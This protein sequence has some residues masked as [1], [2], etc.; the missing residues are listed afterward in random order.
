M[1]VDA[2]NV[3]VVAG[4]P[5]ILGGGAWLLVGPYLV[6]ALVQLAL[7]FLV[8]AVVAVAM[9]GVLFWFVGRDDGGPTDGSTG[10]RVTGE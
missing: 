9:Y 4:A 10:E 5:V 7:F 8:L 2:T 6:W 1:K 3:L